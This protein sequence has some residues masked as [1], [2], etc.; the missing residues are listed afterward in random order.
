MNVD[1]AVED[2][3]VFLLILVRISGFVYT[4]PF[5]SQNS[6]PRKVKIGLSAFMALVIFSSVKG[7]QLE[8]VGI[9]DYAILVTKELIT[10]ILI[11]FSA[12][13]CVFVLSFAGQ[14]IDMEI[15]FSMVTQ[16]D[17]TSRMQTTITSNFYTYL[18]MLI[19]LLSDMHLHLIKAIMDTFNLIPIGHTVFNS[20]LYDGAIKFITDYFIIGFRIILPVFASL[21]VVNIVLGILAKVAPQMNMFVIG[22]QL[23]VFV[24]LF[25]LFFV[26]GLMPQVADF[27]FSEMKYMIQMIVKNLIE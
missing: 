14:M 8:Y 23:K 12:N 27:I 11:G 26:I 9:I 21:L 20:G 22:M 19:M 24:G 4:A 7:I 16:F 2:I 5:L 3:E 25:V 13:M 18:V 6:V 10:G 17:P 1:L 15:G